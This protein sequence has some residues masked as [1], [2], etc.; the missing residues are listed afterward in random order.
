MSLEKFMR[1]ALPGALFLPAAFAPET[2][3]RGGRRMSLCRQA[4][5]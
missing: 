5:L 3:V 2:R 1:A 4:W